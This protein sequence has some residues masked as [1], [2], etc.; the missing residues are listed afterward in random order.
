MVHVCGGVSVVCAVPSRRKTRNDVCRSMMIMV[1]V[2]ILIFSK[3]IAQRENL[4]H[5]VWIGS[6]I[7]VLEYHEMLEFG[8]ENIYFPGNPARLI[9]PTYGPF[10]AALGL[11]IASNDE[12]P[13][14]S[15]EKKKEKQEV[16]SGKQDSEKEYS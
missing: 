7:D 5:I 1:S 9:F 16:N 14:A 3:M 8:A 15:P 2:N 12:E 13:V 4:K 10:L 11:L 6:H